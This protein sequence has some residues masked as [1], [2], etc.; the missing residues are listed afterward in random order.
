MCPRGNRNRASC[1]LRD[2][3]YPRLGAI[4]ERCVAQ[5]LYPAAY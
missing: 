4:P 2:K 1:R 5:N 3:E